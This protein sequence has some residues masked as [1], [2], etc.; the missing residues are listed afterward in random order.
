[1]L[2]RG[3]RASTRRSLSLTSIS[4][5]PAAQ[6]AQSNRTFVQPT[7]VDRATV[8]DAPHIPDEA[9]TPSLDSLGFTLEP[10]KENDRPIYLDVQATA[11]VDPRVLDAMIP[12]MTNQYGNPH[13]RTHAYG[14]E[15]EAAV[16]KARK[17]RISLELTPKI[18]C[19]PP[20]LR[21]PTI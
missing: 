10:V 11:P 1:M 5:R 3:L 14:W 15:A 17:L 8:I 20:V 7:P 16:D 9:F 4:K 2:S 6:V 13:S 18:L 19:L 21:N 12:F